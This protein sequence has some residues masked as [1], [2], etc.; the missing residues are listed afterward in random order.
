M[1]SF[2]QDNDDLR[3][4]LEKA[5]DW[6]TLADVTERGFIDAPSRLIHGRVQDHAL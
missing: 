3:Y 5:I 6:K 4:Y 2:L 1:T